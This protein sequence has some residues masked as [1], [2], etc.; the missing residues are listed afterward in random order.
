MNTI[1]IASATVLALSGRILADT[2]TSATG[3]FSQFSP[4][5]ASSTVQWIGL[6]TPPPS[7]E[8]G[9]PF[10]NNP[11]SD[12]GVGGSHMMNV[13]DLLNDAGGFTGTPSVVGTDTA[14]SDLTAANG[15]DPSAFNFLSTATAYNLSLLYANSSLDTGNAAQGTVFG[16]Y[17]GNT[18]TPLYTPLETNSPTGVTSFDPVASGNSY[19]FYATVCY[20]GGACE[21]YTT[22]EGNFGNTNGAAA[23]N[24]FAVFEL[25]SGSYVIGFEDSKMFGGEGLGDFNDVVV[26]MQVATS[27]EPGSSSLLGIGLAGLAY[28][29]RKGTR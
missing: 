27:P 28:L 7:A 18:F 8:A 20:G 21:T 25:A 3:T 10:W 14:V 22:G 29:L 16:Y 1:L 17:I 24:H 5:F 4:A 13:G 23:W 19:G 26:E 2:V 15:T 6:S 11:S 9:T 12:T